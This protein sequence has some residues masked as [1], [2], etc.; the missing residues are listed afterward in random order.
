MDSEVVPC[1]I[2]FFSGFQDVTFSKPVKI[3][4][5]CP[6]SAD[7]NGY[8]LLRLDCNNQSERRWKGIT[9]LE[10]KESFIEFSVNHFSA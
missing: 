1:P 2:L 7:S 3:R 9:G 4:V 5:P 8:Q 10:R 6:C